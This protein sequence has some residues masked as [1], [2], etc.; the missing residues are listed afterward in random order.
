M[1]LGCGSTT[2]ADIAFELK[3]GV[4]FGDINARK[5]FLYPVSGCNDLRMPLNCDSN[6]TLDG[7]DGND[8]ID[9]SYVNIGGTTNGITLTLSGATDATVAGLSNGDQDT[10]RNFEHVTGTILNDLI[11]GDSN[12]N[13]LTGNEGDDTLYGSGSDDTLD[14][15]TGN[16]SLFGTGGSDRMLG[17]AGQDSLLIDQSFLGGNGSI[18]GGSDFDTVKFNDNSGSLSLTA[19]NFGNV[20]TNIE[21]LDFTAVGTNVT[22]ELNEDFISKLTGKGL[23][24][25]NILEIYQNSG[26]Q[27]SFNPSTDYKC[28]PSSDSNGTTYTFYSATDQDN[29]NPLAQVL[30]H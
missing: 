22:M 21:V 16:D 17:G 29:I 20:V 15:G 19:Q 10:I 12:A 27:I 24:S 3:F 28:L 6:D 9:Y 26:D 7:G 4:G 14:G 8:L 13:K 2:K 5:R 25:T 18:D 11:T 30:V 23:G 1:R